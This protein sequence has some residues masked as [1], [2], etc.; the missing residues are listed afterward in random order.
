MATNV[1]EQVAP[2]RRSVLQKV[3][4]AAA[5]A[6]PGIRTF[7]TGSA[8]VATADAT[9]STC[10]TGDIFLGLQN[11]TF[12]G[13]SGLVPPFWVGGGSPAPGF[14]AYQPGS[15]QYPEPHPTY[16][17]YSPTVFAGSGVLRQLSSI[18]WVGG[19]LYTLNLG[20]GQPLTEPNG[21]TPVNAWPSTVR[22]YLTMGQGSGGSGI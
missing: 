10:E 5:F 20:I 22:V 8:G 14:A 3:I 17:A 7:L 12:T 1:R 15:A 19:Q 18:T 9:V 2:N 6:A 11:P 13:S 16:A 21:N 4:A